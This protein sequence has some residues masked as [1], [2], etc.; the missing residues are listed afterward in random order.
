MKRLAF[1][2]FYHFMLSQIQSQSPVQSHSVVTQIIEDYLESTQSEGFDLNTAFENLTYFYD[3]KLNINTAKEEDLRELILLNEIQIQDFIHYRN[4]YGKFLSIYEL[5]AIPTWNLSLLQNIYPFVK[6]QL[7]PDDFRLKLK[8]A[9]KSGKSQVFLKSRRVLE[10]RHGFQIKEDG[11]KS[12]LGDPFY[13]YARYRYEYG[14]SFKAGLTMEKDPGEKIFGQ[15]SPYGFDFYSFFIYA[16]DLNKTIHVLSLGD[17]AVSLGQGLILHNDFGTGKSS[18]VMN[19]KRAGRTI[20]P[21]SSVN[22]VNFFRGVGTILNLAHNLKASIFLSYKPI[23]GSLQANTRENTDFDSFGSIRLSGLH[24]TESEIMNKNTVAQTHLGGKIE[25]SQKDFKFSVNGLY[26]QLNVP[27]V[28]DQALHR[29]FLFNGSELAHMSTDYSFRKYNFTFFGESAM[30]HN[31]A[32]AHLHGVLIALDK[33]M[34]ISILYRDYSPEYQVL[35]ANAFSDATLP[36][37]E[38]GIY[39]ATEIRPLKNT[40][41]SAYADFWSHPW[42]SYRRNGPAEGK[43]FLI[44]IHYNVRRKIDAYMQYR[45]VHRQRNTTNENS[46][47]YPTDILLQRIRIQSNYKLSKDWEFRNRLE[48]SKFTHEGQQFHGFLTYQDIIFKPMTG[49]FSF[50]GRYTV[51]DVEHFDARIYA[52]ENDLLYEFYIPFFQNR[53]SRFYINTRWRFFKNYSWEFRIFRSFFQNVNQI[54]SG[55]NLINGRTQTELKTQIYIK[56]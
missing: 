5:Q 48:F 36:V 17:Y 26:T 6:C 9:L 30:S 24:R 45:Y 8:D 43:D 18:W 2:M 27:L 46:V 54:S 11:T 55:N 40:T 4:T 39:M 16:K 19:V 49:K 50:S 14:Q 52:Y 22:E 29:K 35:N 28:R 12:F 41:I 13:L 32:W 10:P 7:D 1:L 33:K 20:R 51:F 38:K 42:V 47:A 3:N 25:F 34:D 15:A 56:F 53:G 44:K 31:Q 23:S 37:N 21:Y